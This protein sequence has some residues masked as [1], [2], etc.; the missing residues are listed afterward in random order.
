MD[1]YNAPYNTNK[2]HLDDDLRGVAGVGPHHQDGVSSSSLHHQVL[3][4]AAPYLLAGVPDVVAVADTGHEARGELGE[5]VAERLD[6]SVLPPCGDRTASAIG[7]IISRVDQM[8]ER[9]NQLYC[10]V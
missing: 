1:K 2:S 4:F 9:Y 3:E 10:C 7:Q 6:L 5:H 8:D